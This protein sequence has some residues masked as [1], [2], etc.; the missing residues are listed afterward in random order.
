M[1]CAAETN[2]HKYERASCLVENETTQ[3]NIYDMN[4]CGRNFV[5][6]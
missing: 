2:F 1:L 3:R 4:A 6:S 5:V